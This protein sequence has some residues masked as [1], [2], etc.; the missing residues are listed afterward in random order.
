MS[1][2]RLILFLFLALAACSQH[3]KEP[4]IIARGSER[5]LYAFAGEEHRV[6][7]KALY[8]SSAK[9]IED[10]ENTSLINDIWETT[11]FLFGPLTYRGLGG[12]Q[13]GE[14]IQPLLAQ[15]YIENGRVLVPY[16]YDATWM[17]H[18]SALTDSFL[19]LP[20]PFSVADLKTSHW[21]DCTD[22]ADEHGT[23]GFFWYFWEPKR[24]GCDHRRNVNFQEIEVEVG[25]A[26]PQTTESYP[27]YAR[28][29]HIIDGVPTLSMTF[30]FGYVEEVSRPDPFK[31]RDTGIKEFQRFYRVTKEQL[32]AQSFEESPILQSDITRGLAIIGSQFIGIKDGV[33]V[34]VSIVAAAGVDQMDLFAH[35]YAHN[36]DGFF[37]WFGHSRVGSGFDAQNFEY[38]LKRNSQRYSLTSDYQLVYWAG[39]NSYSYYTLPFFNLKAQLNPETDPQGTRNLDLISNTLPS[40]FIFNAA[41]AQV[42]FQALIQWKK[43]TSYQSIIQKI[44][45]I[46]DSRGAL[47]IVNVL[48]DE[49]NQH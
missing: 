8:R 28:L 12:I 17:I 16:D 20:L 23:W 25:I 7:F 14:K 3:T 34:E 47:V 48:G 26:T 32:L 6:H 13:K 15:A 38:K 5:E 40:L 43:P 30:A 37:G 9:R 27:E 29:I 10:L 21:Q 24:P 35:S 45:K 22:S 42:L 4:S 41:N 31:D 46:A 39:C 19:R 33:R 2:Y 1:V 11:Q 36:H 44:E 18:N 49:D